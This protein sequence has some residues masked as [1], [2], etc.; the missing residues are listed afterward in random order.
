MY[1]S[2]KVVTYF[3]RL[4]PDKDVV[5]FV[6]MKLSVWIVVEGLLNGIVVVSENRQRRCH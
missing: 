1:K 5:S 4:A 3:I 2:K 6:D